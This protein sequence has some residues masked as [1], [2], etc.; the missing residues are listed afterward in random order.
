MDEYERQLREEIAFH[1]RMYQSAIEPLVKQL[2]RIQ[3]I[4]PRRM[5]ITPE[6]AEQL[7][8]LNKK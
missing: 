1:Q 3:A 7:G 8:L 2:V 6:Q 4:R 5:Y